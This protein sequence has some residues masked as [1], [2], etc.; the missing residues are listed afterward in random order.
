METKEGT[1]KFIETFNGTNKRGPWKRW[2]FEM[3]DGKKYSTFDEF[4]GKGFTVGQSVVME[5]K[6]EGKFWNMGTMRLADSKPIK[7]ETIIEG[8]SIISVLKEILQ[9]LKNGNN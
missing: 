1:I 7:E 6:T 8:D 5:G 3:T 9:E 4:I 2:V